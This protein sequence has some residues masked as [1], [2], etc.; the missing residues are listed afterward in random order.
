MKIGTLSVR[1]IGIPAKNGEHDEEPN[2]VGDGNV[3]TVT[4]PQADRLRFP[5]YVGERDTRRGAE[6]DHRATK[7][8]RI[9]KKA[10][11][12]AALFQGERGERDV[13]EH[14]GDEP[15]A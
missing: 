12:I 11:V 8:D 10:P 5:I 7:P 1:N 4:Q 9:G 6:P 3:P 14:R 15:K 2:H 13:V